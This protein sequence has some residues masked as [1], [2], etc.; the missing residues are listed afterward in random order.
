M[1]AR[2]RNATQRSIVAMLFQMFLVNPA[3]V[4]GIDTMK[5]QLSVCCMAVLLVASCVWPTNIYNG[6]ETTLADG[7]HITFLSDNKRHPRYLPFGPDRMEVILVDNLWKRSVKGYTLTW[8]KE[9]DKILNIPLETA[10]DYRF[11]TENGGRKTVSMRYVEEAKN[12]DY[13]TE[14]TVDVLHNHFAIVNSEDWDKALDYI[15]ADDASEY[16]L[17]LY[18]SLSL[19][20]SKYSFKSRDM[21]NV[22]LTSPQKIDATLSFTKKGPLLNV[23]ENQRLVIGNL[24]LEGQQ[25]NDSPVIHV[26]GNNAWLELRGG[27]I[28]N[29]TNTAG[30]GGAVVTEEKGIF[31]MYSGS[32]EGNTADRHGGAAYIGDGSVF[33]MH[34]GSINGNIANKDGGGIYV[35]STANGQSTFFMYDGIIHD[36]NAKNK[37]GGGV[38]IAKSTFEMHGGNINGNIATNDGAGVFIDNSTFTMKGG[39]IGSIASP[40]KRQYGAGVYVKGASGSSRT[41]VMEKGSISGNEATAN[42]GGVYMA[43]YAIVTLKG[44][45]RISDNKAH[46]AGGGIYVSYVSPS[47]YLFTMEGGSIANNDAKYGG[48]IATLGKATMK[49][50][51]ITSNTARNLRDQLGGAGVYI[52]GTGTFTMTIGDGS[53]SGN[54]AA[55]DGGGVYI[56][57]VNTAGQKSFDKQQGGGTIEGNTSG[58]DSNIAGNGKNRGHAVFLRTTP[59]DKYRDSAVQDNQNFSNT[60]TSGWTYP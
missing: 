7:L 42:G 36:N 2:A 5:T 1:L 57:V 20:D 6:R 59:T 60:S 21:I 46:N 26:G 29:N 15:H 18:R 35:D 31:A 34:G 17:W 25:D 58:D 12:I 30:D 3:S 44:D 49:G 19:P 39:N 55:G 45:G 54:R 28:T 32:I 16:V 38:Y 10:E 53:I 23:A 37:S 22:T 11:F 24:T 13:Q 9:D 4:R 47:Q 40:N 56:D 14:F 43:A 27:T 48:G 33:E 41:F 52:G 8:I 51:S 50:G